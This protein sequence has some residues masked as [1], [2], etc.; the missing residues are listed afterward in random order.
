MLDEGDLLDEDNDGI[1]D[2]FYNRK[3]GDKTKVVRYNN[4]TYI[5]DF[6][7]DNKW[8]V[9]YNIETQKT[10]EFYEYIEP[11]LTPGFELIYL[12]MLL[13]IFMIILRKKRKK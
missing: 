4:T 13:A 2:S 3:T 7:G 8:D 11:K 12:L 1:F 10:V 5:I 9:V 6:E